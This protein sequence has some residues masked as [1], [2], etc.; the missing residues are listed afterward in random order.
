MVGDVIREAEIKGVA[1]FLAFLDVFIEELRLDLGFNEE[2]ASNMV[3]SL[4]EALNN[5]FVHGNM[6][7][8][9]LPIF[10]TVLRDN[11]DIVVSVRDS[12]KGFDYG[13]L[14]EDLDDDFLDVPGGRGIMI[15][16]ALSDDLLFNESGNETILKYRLS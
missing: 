14:R 13:L 15:M 8:P 9:D 4:S 2:T 10:L 3:I 16:R 11:D 12:G 5:A 6:Q 1:G 7:N